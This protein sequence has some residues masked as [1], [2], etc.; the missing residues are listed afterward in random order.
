M[1]KWVRI[2]LKYSVLHTHTQ[3]R[4]QYST[5]TAC[6][7]YR[8]M[9][10]IGDALELG[11]GVFPLVVALCWFCSPSASISADDTEETSI[12]QS[13]KPKHGRIISQNT[14]DPNYSYIGR[15]SKLNI[16]LHFI[17]C[18]PLYLYSTFLKI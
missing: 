4:T 5:C 3:A 9:E 6:L 8:D 7:S 11:P 14:F 10:F 13:L 12:S 2:K 17:Q 18:D 1:K 16:H 15:A